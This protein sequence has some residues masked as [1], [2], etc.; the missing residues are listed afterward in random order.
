MFENAFGASPPVPL[1][2]LRRWLVAILC[3]VRVFNISVQAADQWTDISGRLLENLTSNGVKLAWPGGCSGVVINRLNGDVVIKIV[4]QG[5]W[6][7]SDQGATWTR[8]DNNT[9]SG[10]DETGWATT[11]DQNDPR[12]I[13]SFSLD[14]LAGWTTNGS[15]REASWSAAVLCRFR[16]R[17]TCQMRSARCSIHASHCV[18]KPILYCVGMFENV[19]ANLAAAAE[20]LAHLRR[21]L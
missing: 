17:S 21:F 6:R 7:S 11:V 4:G 20:K 16:T 15:K 19:K 18:L 5:L 14:G 8:V 9:I 2:N 3:I 13:A 1:G 10:R 12:R